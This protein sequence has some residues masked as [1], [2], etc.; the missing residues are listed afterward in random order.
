MVGCRGRGCAYSSEEPDFD[1][2]VE[3]ELEKEGIDAWSL[4]DHAGLTCARARFLVERP[5]QRDTLA[6][7]A[8]AP[9]ENRDRRGLA[10]RM[11]VPSAIWL[12][13]DLMP[14]MG[15]PAFPMNH[16]GWPGLR[17]VFRREWIRVSSMSSTTLR[18]ARSEG[19]DALSDVNV[20]AP[21]A[22]AQTHAATNAASQPRIWLTR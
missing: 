17:N 14:L 20:G 15:F 1:G 7:D 12:V 5:V 19:A 11:G 8:E 21:N 2:W 18:G 3:A 10:R 4:V 22:N 16:L 9:I 13:K 6:R